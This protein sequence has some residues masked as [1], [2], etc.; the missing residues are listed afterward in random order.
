MSIF[1]YLFLIPFLVISQAGKAEAENDTLFVP[2]VRLGIDVSGFARHLIEPETITGEIIMDVEW[3]KSHFLVVEGGLLR[4]DVKKE[5]HVYQADGYFVR[6]GP[7]FN[8]LERNPD[9]PNDVILASLRYGYGKLNHE[10]PYVLIP[11]PYWGDRETTIS[12]ENYRAH[13]LEAGIGLKT[14]IW[15]SIFMGWSLRG[16]LMLSDTSSP[17][18]DP[19]FISGFGRSGSNTKLSL[20]YYMMYRIPLR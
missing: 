12:S 18:M 20:H 9:N 4:V 19:Y 11:D 2:S 13:W 7:D 5:T 8:I 10:A 3:R 17:A 6:I 14:E 16:R 1:K 15:R